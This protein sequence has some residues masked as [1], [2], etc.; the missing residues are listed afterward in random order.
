LRCS[1]VFLDIDGE[2]PF[3]RQARFDEAG[4]APCTMTVGDV[5]RPSR[6]AASR[7]PRRTA[8]I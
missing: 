7:V 4:G 5:A 3:R 8:A 1:V 6:I 2:M